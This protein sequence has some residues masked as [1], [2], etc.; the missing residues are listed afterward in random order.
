MSIDV[1]DA[2]AGRPQQML[3]L[4]EMLLKAGADV[5]AKDRWGGGPPLGKR[6]TVVL[7]P[8]WLLAR[9][10]CPRRRACEDGRGKALEVH[11]TNMDLR[12]HRV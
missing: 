8:A 5:N 4:A 7:V 10:C 3:D 11:R 2:R 12:S 9:P 6:N 1:T